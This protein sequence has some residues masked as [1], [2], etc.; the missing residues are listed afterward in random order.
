L[1]STP[2][3][4]IRGLS[5]RYPGADAPV[6][7]ALDFTMAAGE[8]CL[9]VGA[10]GAGK[11]TLLSLCAGRHMLPDDAL[12]VLGRAAFSDTTLVNQVSYI[13]SSFPFDVDVGV[14]QI[15]ERQQGVDAARRELLV[16]VLDV[17]RRWRMARVSDG[18]RRRVQILLGLLRPAQLLLLDEVTTDLDVIARTDLLAFLRAETETRGA[19]ILYATHILDGLETWA[20]H[21]ALLEDGRVRLHAP[22]AG[23]P[24]LD[25]IRRAG[26]A[27]PLLRLVERW[28]RRRRHI[29]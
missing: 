8:R 3:L 23:L 7:D 12:R 13:G 18:Q 1:T 15:L 10:N 14:D 26:A 19:S 24:E 27:A 20:T 9:L 2:A 16:N 22:L 4:A 29:P 17:S 28:L 21:I 6:L 25:E 11:T 5:F